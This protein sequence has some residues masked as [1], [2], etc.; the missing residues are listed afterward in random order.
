MPTPV[1]RLHATRQ[2]AAINAA[3]EGA[4]GP[5][6]AE[7]VWKL[8]RKAKPGIGLRTVFRNLQEQVDEQVLLRVVFPGQPPRYEKPSPR[9]HP[10]FVCLKCSGVFDL[11]GETPDVRGQCEL[12][13]GFEAVGS[14]VTLFGYCA[15]CAGASA[16]AGKKA[17]R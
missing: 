14:E 7:E 6:S 12:P 1:K 4:K 15:E 17:G 10:H 11:P 16:G 5:L 9:H 13:A 2:R 3:L 8:A